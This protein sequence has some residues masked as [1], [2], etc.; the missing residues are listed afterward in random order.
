MFDRYYC[1]NST[2]YS[3]EFFKSKYGTIFCCRFTV[4]RWLDI[5]F[6]NIHDPGPINISAIN[7]SAVV[8]CT[9][10]PV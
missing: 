10:K 4:N 2:I 7:G 1:I 3:P 9:V 6:I 8:K 5:L